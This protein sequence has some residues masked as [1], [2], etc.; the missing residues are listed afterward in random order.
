MDKKQ[1]KKLEEKILAGIYES[2]D[3]EFKR[4]ERSDIR[5]DIQS[6]FDEFEEP[7]LLWGRVQLSSLRIWCGLEADDDDQILTALDNLAKHGKLK[8]FW[9]QARREMHYNDILF[10]VEIGVA[11]RTPFPVNQKSS[12]VRLYYEE[13]LRKSE[14]DEYSILNSKERVEEIRAE[15]DKLFSQRFGKIVG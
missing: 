8:I 9:L 15:R 3:I 10:H 4:V 2:D 5:C 7:G 13:P 12:V 6:E 11:K 1:S 14:Q